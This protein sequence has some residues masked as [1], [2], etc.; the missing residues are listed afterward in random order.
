MHAVSL[1]KHVMRVLKPALQG[2]QGTIKREIAS[3]ISKLYQTEDGN[4]YVV[5]RREGNIAVFVAVAGYGLYHSRNELIDFA[6]INHFSAIRFHTKHPER[7]RKGLQ[8]LLVKRIAV[9]KS[10][11]ARDEWVYLLELNR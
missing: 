9:N 4:L 5:I 7:L 2:A 6:R 3:G 11:F 8:G 10:L 1:T